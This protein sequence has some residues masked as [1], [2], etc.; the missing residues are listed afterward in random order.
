MDAVVAVHDFG[1][2]A[3]AFFGIVNAEEQTIALVAAFLESRSPK[4]PIG[5]LPVNICSNQ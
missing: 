1:K 3:I 4:S 5:N 2:G